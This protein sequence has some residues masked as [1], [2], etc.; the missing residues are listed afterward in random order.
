MLIVCFAARIPTCFCGWQRLPITVSGR[1]GS[2]RVSHRITVAG[3]G[4]IPGTYLLLLSSVMLVASKDIP[5]CIGFP[6]AKWDGSLCRLWP[7]F[8]EK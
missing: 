2:F 4:Q 6:M 7:H 8:P 5:D 3:Y 1:L